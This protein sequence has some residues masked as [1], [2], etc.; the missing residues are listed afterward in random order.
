MENYPHQGHQ[1]TDSEN[2]KQT[3]CKYKNTLR[4]N[5]PESMEGFINPKKTARPNNPTQTSTPISNKFSTLQSIQPPPIILD[6]M[7]SSNIEQ[8]FKQSKIKGSFALASNG[9]RVFPET[10]EDH[11]NLHNLLNQNNVPHHTWAPKGTKR[12]HQFIILGLENNY[13]DEETIKEAFKEIQNVKDI[14]RMKKSNPDGTKTTIEP[15]IITIKHTED[16]KSQIL[17]KL[18][19]T[20]QIGYL[21]C[22]IKEYQPKKTIPQCKN[23][24]QFGH[25][26]RYCARLPVCVRCSEP[27]KIEDCPC[28]NQPK[29][30]NCKDHHVASFRRCPKF[31]E[32]SARRASYVRT[33]SRPPINNSNF[34]PVTHYPPFNPRN[35][36]QFS[37][38]ETL[39]SPNFSNPDTLTNIISQVIQQ[40]IKQII[41]TI[42]KT[43]QNS[44][45]QC[46]TSTCTP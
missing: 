22:T 24:Q 20:R 21:R 10:Y 46:F 8:I 3:S 12:D 34:S 18:Q 15:V 37:Y 29:C 39:K 16:S 2:S 23:C 42:I 33:T 27:H 41:P 11:T 31:L 40:I 28:S 32:E 17:L 7:T 13:P 14:R 6:K 9:V 26:R 45:T 25:T 44:L 38:A 5:N 4:R 43:I 35:N 19:E 30:A 1:L 36:Q